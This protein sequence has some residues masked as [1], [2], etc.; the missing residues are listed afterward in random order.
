MM[1]SFTRL[2]P[3]TFLKKIHQS[4]NPY[5]KIT[6]SIL[7]CASQKEVRA[8]MIFFSFTNLLFRFNFFAETTFSKQCICVNI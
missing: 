6:H 5:F 7:G 4:F 3:D 2:L 1:T 8:F